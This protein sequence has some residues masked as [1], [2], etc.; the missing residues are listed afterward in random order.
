MLSSIALSSLP[1]PNSIYFFA[2]FFL[3]PLLAL[4][5]WYALLA[6]TY[7]CI[8]TEQEKPS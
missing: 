6:C 5:S 2:L 7:L 1:F 4:C 3:H 8:A